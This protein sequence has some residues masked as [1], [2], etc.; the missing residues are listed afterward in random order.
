M[1]RAVDELIKS[2]L[3][4]FAAGKQTQ[5]ALEE[6]ALFRL[7]NYC[8]PPAFEMTDGVKANDPHKKR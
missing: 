7:L 3:D 1:S 6:K 5:E 4:D 2:I 8:P